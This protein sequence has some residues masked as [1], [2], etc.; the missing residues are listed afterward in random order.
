MKLEI[1]QSSSDKESGPRCAI[2]GSL[3]LPTVDKWAD[4]HLATR[5]GQAEGRHRRT[6][7]LPRAGGDAKCG[8]GLP[9]DDDR[10]LLADSPF[11][12]CLGSAM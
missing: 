8:V 5:P 1:C 3:P 12:R 9:R 10:E 6:M 7:Y 2:N 4:V 11:E